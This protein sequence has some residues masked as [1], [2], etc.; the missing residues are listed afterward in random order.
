MNLPLWLVLLAVIV[1]VVREIYVSRI[2]RERIDLGKQLIA[3]IDKDTARIRELIEARK[4]LYAERQAH[5]ATHAEMVRLQNALA[6]AEVEMAARFL[7]G[8]N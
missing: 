4:Q 1:S 5:L 3:Q 2:H 8:R 7:G 6:Q